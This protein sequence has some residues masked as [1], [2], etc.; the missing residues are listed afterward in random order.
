MRKCLNSALRSLDL[1]Q[2][3][4]EDTTG[5]LDDSWRGHLVGVGYDDLHHPIQ[6]RNAEGKDGGGPLVGYGV[7]CE[8]LQGQGMF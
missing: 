2:D 4:L 6:G 8:S 5:G 3:V 1:V 7:H